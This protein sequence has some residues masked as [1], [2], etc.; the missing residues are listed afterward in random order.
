[1][2]MSTHVEGIAPPDEKWRLMKQIYESC[3]EADIP[4]PK[5]VDK[6]FNYEPPDEDGVVIPL[7]DI[8]KDWT[9]PQHCASGIEIELAKIPKHV[10]VLRIVNSC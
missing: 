2:G 3:R 8:S 5:E 10:K 4:V 6:F 1:M 9:H 7:R